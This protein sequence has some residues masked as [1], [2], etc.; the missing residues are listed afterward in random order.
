MLVR[1]RTHARARVIVRVA[2]LSSRPSR[3]LS[4]AARRCFVGEEEEGR[5]ETRPSES[6]G[7]NIFISVSRRVFP[8]AQEAAAAK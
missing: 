6:T 3:R 5:I 7:Y 4:R 8:V 1:A 2:Q